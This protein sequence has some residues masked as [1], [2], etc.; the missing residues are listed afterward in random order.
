MPHKPQPLKS[1]HRMHK[2][3]GVRRLP[4]LAEDKYKTSFLFLEAAHNHM[5]WSKR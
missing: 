2:L 5:A 3:E 1:E 4:L